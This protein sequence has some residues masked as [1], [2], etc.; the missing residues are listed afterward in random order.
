MSFFARFSPVRAIQDLR[1]YLATRPPYEIVFLMLAMAATGFLIYLF[2]RNDIAPPPYR[3]DIIYV[4]QWPMSRT[5][6]E[7][8]A[9]QKIDQKVKAKRLADQQAQRD[10]RR[11]QFKKLD[12]TLSKW[13]I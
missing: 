9:A 6:A 11:A 3:A 1:S 12:D 13:G 7:I 2:A 10:A 5:D 4:E 8:R